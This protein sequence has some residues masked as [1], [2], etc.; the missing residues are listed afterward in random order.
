MT[1]SSSTSC[2]NKKYLI[3]SFKTRIISYLTIIPLSFSESYSYTMTFTI[4][5]HVHRYRLSI[6]LKIFSFPNCT[7][8]INRIEIEKQAFKLLAIVLL[9]LCIFGAVAEV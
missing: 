3:I 6:K 7:L 8:R 5:Y 1:T 4:N 9:L 2:R